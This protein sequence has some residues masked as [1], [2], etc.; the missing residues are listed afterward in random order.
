MFLSDEFQDTP[1]NRPVDWLAGLFHPGFCVGLFPQRDASDRPLEL[2]PS[3][4]AALEYATA[5]HWQFGTQIVFTFGPLG[6]L[7]T[8]TSLGHLV[9]ARIAFAFFWSALV[10]LAATALAKRLP[11]WVRY[12]FLA[13][14]VVFTLSE[15]LDQTAFFVMASGTLLL[16]VD[17]PE[18]RWQAPLF[19]FAFIVL[20]LIKVS[21][22][23]AAIAS[24]ALVVVCWIRQRKI[25]QGDRAGAGG[26]GG[27]RR[28][29]GWPWGSRPPTLPPG[30]G[31][32]WSWS[33]ATARQ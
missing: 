6:F 10:A 31:T 12:A 33:L 13:W 8:R 22:L 25:L 24:L 1:S 4:H 11:G 32:P 9:G 18:Q 28:A 29:A 17:N 30:S 27:I 21:F 7:S 26:A 14:F 5:H 19:V 2:D 15:G 3:W 23:T 20:S 16:L